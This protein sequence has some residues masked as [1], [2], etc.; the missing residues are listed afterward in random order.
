MFRHAAI[1]FVACAVAVC[2]S[3]VPAQP[4]LD[5]GY[6]Q[7]Y[8]LQF[9]E[10]HATFTQWER[11][12]PDDPMGPVSEA[13]AYLFSEFDRLRILQSEFFVDNDTFLNMR[14]LTPDPAVKRDFENA[15]TRSRLLANQ[16]LARSPED[17]NALFAAVLRLGLHADYLALIEKRYLASLSEVKSGRLLALRLLKA[18]P[19]CYDAYLAI[20]VEN[21]V[22]SLKPAPLRWLLRIGGA[23]TDR[24]E[25]I[26]N[27]RLTAEKGRLLLPY[28]RLLLAVA[29]L[30]DRDRG[31]AKAILRDLA[32]EF[33]RNQLYTQELSRLQ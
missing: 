32:K 12:Y 33:P 9:G 31:R 4:G 16:A 13:A 10:A 21:Y 7:M 15:L 29:A 8:N 2:A 5:L 28:A 3:S 23:Q 25:G 14:K 1:G 30:R 6:R 20:G 17:R 22:L 27:L 24:G 26:R 19:A 18:D 11:S